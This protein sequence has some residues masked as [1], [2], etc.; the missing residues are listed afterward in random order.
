MNEILLAREQR[1]NHIKQLIDTSDGNTIAVLKLNVVGENKNPE[2]MRFICSLFHKYMMDEFGNKVVKFGK[3]LSKDGDYIYYVIKEKGTLVKERTI[4]IE[5]TNYFGRLVDIDVY[6]NKGISRSD[7]M[8]EMRKCLICDNYAHVCSRN[9]THTVDEI[10]NKVKDIIKETLPQMVLSE[11][12]SMIHFEL[13]L[14][15]RF[16][17]VGKMDSGSHS[18]MN[19]D[20][21]IESTFAIKPYIEKFILMGINDIEPKMLQEIGLDAEKAMFSATKGV[22][23][24]KGLIFVLGIFLPALV[25]TV[26]NHRDEKYL[27][28]L[29]KNIAKDIIGDYYEKILSKDQLSHGDTIYLEHG[30]KGVRGEALKGFNILFEEVPNKNGSLSD[31]YDCLIYLMSRL[32]DTTIIHKKGIDV[33]K[34]VQKEMEELIQLGGFKGNQGQ[35]NNLSERYKNEGISPGGSSDMLVA[36]LIYENFKYLV[37]F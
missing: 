36:M 13:D 34:K 17:L 25:K 30:I 9:Q 2:Y 32:E 27:M 18:D 14:Y 21:F 5:D 24:Q 4:Y 10:H 3:V 11:V 26:I 7:M 6:H 20:M 16:G 15:P 12:I 8:C 23:T 33:L 19:Y 29:M 28:D 31:P 37:K 22:N 35:Y 1:S